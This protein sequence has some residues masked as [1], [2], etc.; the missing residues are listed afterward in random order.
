[1]VGSNYSFSQDVAVDT[2]LEMEMEV[3][4]EVEVKVDIEQIIKIRSHYR[5]T[6]TVIRNENQIIPLDRLDTLKIASLT[7]GAG[8][9]SIF[10]ERVSGYT[11]VD[12]FYLEQAVIKSETENILKKLENYNLLLLGIDSL[13]YADKKNK[14]AQI[15]D[16]FDVITSTIP[17]ILVWWGNTK[18]LADIDGFDNAK[19]VLITF[20]QN[21]IVKDFSAQIIFGGIGAVGILPNSIN[22]SYPEGTGLNTEGNIRFCYALPGEV[23]LD[24]DFL[25]RKIDS[26][27]N[28]ALE[29]QV[30]PG[31]QVL[32]A[33]HQKVVFHRTYGYH[34]YDS[35]IPVKNDDIYDLASITK[36]TG[37]LPAL[38]ALHDQ[39]KFSLD[40]TLGDYLEYYQKGNKKEIELRKILSHNAQLEAWIPFWMTTIKK[41][42][43]FKKKTLS[44]KPSAE[45][46]IK[47]TDSLYLYKRYQ[48]QIYKM[49]RKSDLLPE[50]GYVYSGLS[51]YLYPEIIEN[52][53]NED[54]ETHLKRTF[55]EPLGAYTVTYN[56][57]KH[58]TLDRI[59]PT[60][61]DTFFRKELIHGKVHDEGAAMMDGV[62]SNAGLFA[63]ADDL[64]KI[65]QMYLNMGTYGGRRYITTNT[66]EKFTFCHYCEEGNRRGLAFD[67]PV[68][69]N[70]EEGSTAI[71]ASHRS[72]GHSGYTGTF[73]WADP[74][75]GILFIFL[76]NRVHPTRE[77]RKLYELN[78]RPLMHQV[79]YDARID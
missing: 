10:Q 64:A 76:S 12:H 34:T 23:G 41:N 19:A 2:L 56:P 66:V 6:I 9:K 13:D 37:A 5:D 58:F 21:D 30:A 72:F 60:E 20:Q 61:I 40:A 74:E 45:Y 52:L 42:G 4:V 36:I 70:K 35:L 59:I 47:L 18:D 63:S 43:K 48:Q 77:N 54:F 65:M 39:N 24:G 32:I 3:E 15:A 38:M 31:L 8:G 71:D 29:A 55:Y 79:I 50:E 11:R 57:Y 44:T 1:M 28:I 75:T 14:L 49:I 27:A 17:T 69:E 16:L 25:I 51:F 73:A 68:M 53:T 7:I 67:K 46:S 22:D 78:I 33:R 26:I 62:S